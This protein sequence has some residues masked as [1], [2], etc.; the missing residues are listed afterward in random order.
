MNLTIEDQALDLAIG[1]EDTVR[2]AD[3]EMI[4][5]QE[6]WKK[7]GASCVDREATSR[8]IV[9]IREKGQDQDP[10][11]T[12]ERTPEEMELAR[13]DKATVLQEAEAEAE[14]GSQV[15]V[16]EEATVLILRRKTETV[17]RVIS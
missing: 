4:V 5:S 9:R 8:E 13:E 3:Q 15:A 11:L 16:R 6:I 14:E 12:E 7:E 17:C 1:T 10:A 2:E